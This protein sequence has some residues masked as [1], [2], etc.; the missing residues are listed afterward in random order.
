MH[1]LYIHR[2]FPPQFAPL[3]K[4]LER[5]KGWK[6]TFLSRKPDQ[7]VEGLTNIQYHAQ[8]NEERNWDLQFGEQLRHAAAVAAALKKRPELR[9]DLVVAHSGFGSSCL[10]PTVRDCPIINYFEY[11]TRPLAND[12]LFR[13]EW[14]HE[15][16]YYQWRRVANAMQLLDLQT[17][18]A[19]YSPT[20][21]QRSTF[22][23]EHHDKIDVLFDGVDIATFQPAAAAV[24]R[25]VCGHTIPEGTRVVT[26]V[27]RGL[28]LVRG[29]D[30][31]MKLAKRIYTERPATIFLVAGKDRVCYGTDL[32][33]TGAA[34]FKQWVLEQDE[35]DLSKF[36][37]LDWIPV[38]DLVRLLHLSDLHVYLTTP[39]VLSWSLF[40][41]LACGTT[42]L[43]SD[44]APVR[45]VVRDGVNGL[46]VD[47]HDLDGMA[48]RAL[49]V[50]RDPAAFHPLGVAAAAEMRARYSFEVMLPK[51]IR[52][53]ER[54]ASS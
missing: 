34:S 50:L 13:A 5:V 3:A 17:C 11:Y 38:E 45:E 18:T 40:N 52:Y 7:V 41:A 9:P 30:V 54:I 19:G 49:E 12:M 20:R 46:L 14:K 15:D 48:I 21:W 33:L 22:P 47:F 26:Y 53:F 16:W 24:P 35:Y 29:F 2:A 6:A 28:E 4:A 23:A 25:V 37:F 27:A 1:I 44:V 42:V 43:A 51:F 10:V 36:I 31:F 32:Q 39:F 8:D